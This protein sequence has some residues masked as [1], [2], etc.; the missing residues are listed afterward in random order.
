MNDNN[1]IFFS[2]KLTKDE[3]EEI[4]KE[5]LAK[6]NKKLIISWNIWRFKV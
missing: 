3:I 4:K 1:I 5:K 6:K 2:W